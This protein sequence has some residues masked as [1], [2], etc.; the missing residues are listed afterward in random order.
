MPAFPI[1]LGN[2]PLRL[3]KPPRL[4]YPLN[5]MR[6]YRR[7]LFGMLDPARELV[8]ERI[9]PLLP[10]L[11]F[12]ATGRRDADDERTDQYAETISRTFDTMRVDY[13]RVVSDGRVDATAKKAADGTNTHNSEQVNNQVRTVLGVDVFRGNPR[14]EADAAAFVKQNVSLIKSLPER[15][16]SEVEQIVLQ[17]VTQGKRAE[18]I[19]DE[20][21]RRFDVARSR[22]DFIANDQVG[23]LN[24]LLTERRHTDLGLVRYR[25]RNSRDERVRGNPAGKYPKAKYSHHHR[26]GKTFEYSEPPA[27]GNPGQPPRCRCW[28]EPVFEDVLP[29]KFAVDQTPAPVATA[30]NIF[31]AEEKI[32]SRPSTKAPVITAEM[33]LPEAENAIRRRKVEHMGVFSAKG[34]ML[35]TN[36][37]GPNT[38]GFSQNALAIMKKR[39]DV[40]VT[41]NH[42]NDSPFS[43][44][45]IVAAVHYNLKEIRACL[46]SG[47]AWV[48]RRPKGGWKIGGTITELRASLKRTNDL[49]YDRAQRQHSEMMRDGR[50]GRMGV[51]RQQQA[52]IR[53]WH[54]EVVR[55]YNEWGKDYGWHVEFER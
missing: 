20:L 55:A 2:A 5:V 18:V 9:V 7:D 51:Q 38:V 29:K 27:D 41:H 4:T 11:I 44:A 30:A 31:R 22:A 49:A 36:V 13:Q 42:P 10:S 19:A 16:F 25:W 43:V 8:L 50:R 39:T 54:N 24:G 6:S 52:L 14:L 35:D 48:L 23:K 12:Q 3:R 40:R 46:P 1:P 45:D 28:A 17:N 32:R 21:E 34:E 15:Y 47:G 26:E 53:L 33:S 37:G